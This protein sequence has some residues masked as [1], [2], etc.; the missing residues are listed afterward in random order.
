ML[1]LWVE[2]QVGILNGEIFLKGKVIDCSTSGSV[3]G[4]ND[5]GG[6]TGRLV[7]SIYRDNKMSI[8]SSIST[9]NVNGHSSIRG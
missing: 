6:I 7:T 8:L 4:N 2:T 5:V 3:Y 9:A 1:M